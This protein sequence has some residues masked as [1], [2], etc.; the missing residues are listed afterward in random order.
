MPSCDWWRADETV[1]QLDDTWTVTDWAQIKFSRSE[2]QGQD[3]R[4]GSRGFVRVRGRVGTRK[5]KMVESS[6]NIQIQDPSS[7]KLKV[8]ELFFQYSL[9]KDI[10]NLYILH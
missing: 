3:S 8:I 4:Y 7:R 10:I 1:R 9:T 2:T 6:L 5:Y